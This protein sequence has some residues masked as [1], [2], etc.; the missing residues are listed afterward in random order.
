MVGVEFVNQGE[1]K[2][3]YGGLREIWG[4]GDFLLNFVIAVIIATGGY[5]NDFEGE[6]SLLKKYHPQVR[7]FSFDI[8][9][10]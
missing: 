5:A 1:T 6:D 3:E 10:I 7:L 9:L 8:F 2:R 4:V